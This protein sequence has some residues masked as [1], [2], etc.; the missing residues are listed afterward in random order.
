MLEEEVHSERAWEDR[1]G[2]L[3]AILAV[4]SR[5]TPTSSK[6]SAAF[7]HSIFRARSTVCVRFVSS[8]A[9][10]GKS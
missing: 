10:S 4:L 5:E 2:P 8:K 1:R 3:H 6:P 9:A 7:A